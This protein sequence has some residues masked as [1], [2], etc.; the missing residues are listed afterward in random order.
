MSSTTVRVGRDLFPVGAAITLTAAA[1]S[2]AL[3]FAALTSDTD[4]DLRSD[5]SSEAP[6]VDG[7]DMPQ[8]EWLKGYLRIGSPGDNDMPQP[9]WL[10]RYLR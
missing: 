3:G 2:A 1:V 5:T 8:P 9:E 7:S 6:A 10:K 4:R